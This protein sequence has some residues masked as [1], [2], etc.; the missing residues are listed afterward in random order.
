[1]NA[2]CERWSG[3]SGKAALLFSI[4][5]TVGEPLNTGSPLLPHTEYSFKQPVVAAF[6]LYLCPSLDAAPLWLRIPA[7]P[8]VHACYYF[9]NNTWALLALFFIFSLLLDLE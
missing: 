1:M 5:A 9:K 4:S 3:E 8:Q 6:H 7:A 2:A